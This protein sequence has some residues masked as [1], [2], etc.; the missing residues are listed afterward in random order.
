MIPSVGRIVHYVLAEG[1]KN[2]GGHRAAQ[3]TAIYNDVKGQVTDATPVDLR[4]TLQPHEAK[5]QAEGGPDG[6]IDVEVAFQDPTGTKPGTWHEPERQE[7]AKGTEMAGN[8]L[9]RRQAVPA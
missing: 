8:G 3:I 2:K 6:F 9:R 7:A 1:H 4:V 5:G